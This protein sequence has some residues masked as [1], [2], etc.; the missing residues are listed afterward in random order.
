MSL[1]FDRNLIW[2]KKSEENCVT[3]TQMGHVYYA[4]I[5]K[6]LTQMPFC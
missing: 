3:Q 2:Q 6:G 1:I 5:L 4:T